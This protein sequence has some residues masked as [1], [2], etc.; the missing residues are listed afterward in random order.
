MQLE[1]PVRWGGLATIV[2]GV[3]LVVSE[4]LSTYFDYL[5]ADPLAYAMTIAPYDGA[6]G[7]LSP[8]IVQLGLIGLY[9]GQAR[10]AGI[11]GL[12]GF[13]LAFTGGQFL[14]PGASF[15][16]PFR[17]PYFWPWEFA[18]ELAVEFFGWQIAVAVVL[19]LFF[20]VGWVLLGVTALKTH[21]YP[22]AA[23]ALLIAGV[24]I[25]LLPVPL[26]GVIFAA[27]LVWL[28]YALFAKRSEQ[29]HHATGRG[30]AS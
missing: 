19:W 3:L 30:V 1:N 5:T 24:L 7:F 26:G 4:L 14:M 11:L 8:V 10:A 17:E 29:A 27:A 2:A 9:A 16:Y 23:A 15:V 18:E 22:R 25:L 21:I 28:G 6:I 13:V 12:V 20:V